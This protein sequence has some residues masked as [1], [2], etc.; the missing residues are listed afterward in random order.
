MT[1]EPQVFPHSARHC[2]WGLVQSKAEIELKRAALEL[3]YLHGYLELGDTLETQWP[4]PCALT[5]HR[6]SRGIPEG[7]F[8][9]THTTTHVLPLVCLL[10]EVR[11]KHVD[12]GV[13]SEK[14]AL[15]DSPGNVM[16]S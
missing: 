15:W 16:G 5:A 3:L 4:T 7:R 1:A 6:I 13:P 9:A 2:T 10:A 11:G 14:S 12:G 8:F